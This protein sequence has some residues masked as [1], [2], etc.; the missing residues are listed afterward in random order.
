M[1]GLAQAIVFTHLHFA[2][3]LSQPGYLWH[4]L[5][6]VLGQQSPAQNLTGSFS[7]SPF[8]AELVSLQPIIAF[9]PG[10]HGYVNGRRD[11]FQRKLLY[12]EHVDLTPEALRDMNEAAIQRYHA[13]VAEEAA[14]IDPKKT[15][16]EVMAAIADD[17]PA[18]DALLDTARQY[19]DQSR[20]F[21]ID[22]KL[23][24]LPSD[25]KPI[26]RPTPAYARTGFASMSTPGPFETRATQA[27]YNITTVDP[28][29]N[30]AQT[31]QHL[32]YFNR[33]GLLGI[34]VHEAFPGHFV[35][36]LYRPQLPT[37]LRKVL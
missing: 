6:P 30:Q 12:E 1:P 37:P 5:R 13:W 10:L 9:L 4:D 11:L 2:E 29:W 25:D 18:P 8:P 23:L 21:I 33:P 28:T 24:T 27:Y 35:Q 16:A 32:T 36:L 3:W 19:M 20:Q 17:Y 34:T 7:P 15:P 31:H 22:R 14:R 26:V